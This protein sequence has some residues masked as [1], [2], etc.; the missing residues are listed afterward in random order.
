MNTYLIYLRYYEENFVVGA[1][2][3]RELAEEYVARFPGKSYSI[4][5]TPLRTSIPQEEIEP[6]SS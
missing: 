5:E 1:F 3:S 4:R 2:A 6:I